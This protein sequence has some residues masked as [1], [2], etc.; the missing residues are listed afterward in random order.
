M[1]Y[2][3]IVTRLH[4]NAQRSHV[5]SRH[6]VI[7]H[8]G[9]ATGDFTDEAVRRSVSVAAVSIHQDGTCRNDVTV[10]VDTK[11]WCLH[12]YSYVVIRDAVVVSIGSKGS[13]RLAVTFTINI[14]GQQ[15]TGDR[16]VE[17]RLVDVVVRHRHV[18]RD[19]GNREGDRILEVHIIAEDDTEGVLSD[20][21]GV[22]RVIN[23][24]RVKVVIGDR[25]I[26]RFLTW[27]RAGDDSR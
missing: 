18:D 13:D 9:I 27:N 26:L 6:V 16:S 20:E 4:S 8:D 24:T 1:W 2:D 3:G 7:V 17:R 21:T 14:I 19:D 12:S 22:R 15:V 10:H 5:R 23:T 25:T 11:D